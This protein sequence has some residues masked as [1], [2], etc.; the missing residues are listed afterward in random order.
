LIKIP[1]LWKKSNNRNAS[2]F[3]SFNCLFNYLSQ[4]T[5]PLNTKIIYS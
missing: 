3:Y 5:P 2:H 4:E 1:L